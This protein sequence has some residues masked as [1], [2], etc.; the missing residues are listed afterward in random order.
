[1]SKKLLFAIFFLTFGAFAQDEDAYRTDDKSEKTGLLDPS[2]FSYQQSLS[3]GMMSG[4]GISNLKSQSLYNTMLQ[5]KMA[6]PVTLNLNFGLPIH[7]TLS[8]AQNLTTDNLQSLDYFK[9]IPFD[10]SLTWQPSEKM[11]MRFS[12]ARETYGN[13]YLLDQYFRSVDGFEKRR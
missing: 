13:S 10:F 1:M 7:S 11:M 9:S 3:F 5:Y 12:V 2:R 4:S 6:A 8:S